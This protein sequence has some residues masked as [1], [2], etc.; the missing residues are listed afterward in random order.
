ML[1]VVNYSWH[2]GI[3]LFKNCVWSMLWLL[4]LA[5]PVSFRKKPFESRCACIESL[6]SSDRPEFWNRAILWVKAK[7][8]ISRQKAASASWKKK[9]MFKCGA[10]LVLMW[11][12]CCVFVP[13]N[14]AF[15]KGWKLVLQEEMFNNQF[16]ILKSSGKIYF[17]KLILICHLI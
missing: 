16:T 13:P 4:Y 11:Q 6:P 12:L 9:K 10:D 2:C 17:C 5:K 1:K 8:F 3:V 15:A 7:S 14:R